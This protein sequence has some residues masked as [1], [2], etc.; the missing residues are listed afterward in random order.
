MASLKEAEKYGVFNEDAR[1][2]AQAFWPGPITLVVPLRADAGLSNLVTAGLGSV[3]L[4]VPEA[5]LAQSLLQAFQGPVAAPSANPSGKISPSAAAHVVDGLSGRIDAILDGGTCEVG[6][7][8]TIVG[9]IAAPTLL[10]H[11]GVPKE[12]I[13]QCLGRELADAKAGEITAPGQLLSHYAPTAAV[14]LNATEKRAGEL[15]VGFGD[16]KD[17]DLSLSP[18][19][20]L[21]EAAAHLFDILHQANALNAS[22]IAFAP[23]PE[24]GLGHAI[25]DRLRR[26]AAPR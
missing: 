10:R 18:S 6:L 9:C 23:I 4:R 11:G 8:S 14:R 2:L 12:A 25:N 22:K 21:H 7:E 15:L 1:A 24:I 17:A 13:E 5:A 16:T 3:G 19:G 26:A 20:D